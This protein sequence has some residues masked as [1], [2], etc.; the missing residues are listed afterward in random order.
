MLPDVGLASAILLKYGIPLA[1]CL[2]SCAEG[3]TDTIDER[4]RNNRMCQLSIALHDILAERCKVLPSTRLCVLPYDTKDFEG[5]SCCWNRADVF[6]KSVTHKPDVPSEIATRRL[7]RTSHGWPQVQP[8][9]QVESLTSVCA[10]M[11]WRGLYKGP[12][13]GSQSDHK[14][15]KSRLPIRGLTLFCRKYL[16][17]IVEYMA[18]M[19]G[20]PT[21]PAENLPRIIR[22]LSLLAPRATQ[23]CS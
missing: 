19:R 7:Q 16:P 12:S 1:S 4:V 2:P 8:T 9:G 13:K 15:T 14:S 23:K 20:M 22:C 18:C 5:A 17:M 11:P 10:L 3:C 21:G 6:S